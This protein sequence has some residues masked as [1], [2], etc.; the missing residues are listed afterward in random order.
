[1]DLVVEPQQQQRQEAQHEHELEHVCQDDDDVGEPAE[2]NGRRLTSRSGRGP[3]AHAQLARDPTHRANARLLT[4]RSPN[5][6]NSRG[7]Q[8]VEPPRGQKVPQSW[9]VS[10]FLA[11]FL[12]DGW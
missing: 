3:P 6:R 12:S 11:L 7:L 5:K 1:M 9:F 4:W 2:P 8:H 10:G